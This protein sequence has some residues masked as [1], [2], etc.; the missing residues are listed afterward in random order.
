MNNIFIKQ[1]TVYL[2][3]VF[4]NMFLIKIVFLYLKKNIKISNIK[5][6]IK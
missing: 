4:S 6:Y 5:I 3:L 1:Q 2:L